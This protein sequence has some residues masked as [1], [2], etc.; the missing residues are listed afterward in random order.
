MALPLPDLLPVTDV[1]GTSAVVEAT[2]LRSLDGA[3]V[4][5]LRL[6]DG[7][8]LL[9][10]AAEIGP[11][12]GDA[13]RY[14]GAF[15]TAAGAPVV[16]PLVEER[17]RVTTRVVPRGRVRVRRRVEEVVERVGVDL[18]H[19]RVEVVRVPTERVV[20][21]A[22]EPWRDGETL[23]IPV[24]EEV[25]EVRTRFVVRE[26][27]RVTLRA[28]AARHEEDVVVR[29]TRVDVERLGPDPSPPG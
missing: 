17:A 25:V 1:T 29:R 2:G 13:R 12:D 26:E 27:V 5:V 20:D 23:V 19:H 14:A 6:A 22:P 16:L 11:G 9:V 10:P 7:R 4:A 15:E 24:V 3:A 8:R 28:E 21:A 18:T